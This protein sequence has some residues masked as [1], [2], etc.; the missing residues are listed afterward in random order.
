MIAASASPIRKDW[1]NI[2]FLTLSPVLAVPVL[3]W[4][5]FHTGFHWWMPS[6]TAGLYILVGLSI[7]A[8]YHRYFSH[9]SYECS[10]WV[11]LFYAIFGAMAA[12][13]SILRWSAGHRRH[14]AYPEQE[15]DPYS[16][17]RGF[18]WAHIVWIFHIDHYANRLDN[19]RDLQ[20]NPVVMWQHRWY[21]VLLLA[22]GLGLPTLIG[23]LFGNALAGLLWGGFLRIV[24]VHHSTFFVN[25]IAHQFGTPSYDEKS[26]ARDNWA[27]ALLTFGEGYHSFHHRFPGDFRNGISWYAWDPAKWFIRGLKWLGLAKALNAT[28]EPV[29]EQARIKVTA[30]HVE[31]RIAKADPSL[32]AQLAQRMATARANLEAAV[33]L[34]SEQAELR[35]QGLSK[36]WR[37][38]YRS[39]RARLKQARKEW[40]WILRTVNQLAPRP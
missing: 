28:P 33:H 27:V 38:T 12:Q 17:R 5:T 36:Q 13:N 22:G 7:C 29:I 40:R 26:S 34:W 32:K 8:G 1:V 24:L 2:V 19:V 39:Y 31:A 14:H 37:T 35:R 21:K 25:S 9:R 30:R 18:W 6:L 15:W 3:A 4:H 11:Q 10:R 16:I 20:K 23:A